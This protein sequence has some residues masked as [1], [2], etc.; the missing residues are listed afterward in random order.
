MLFIP[1]RSKR[2]SSCGSFSSPRCCGG[3]CP[4][5]IAPRM[6]ISPCALA[7]WGGWQAAKAVPPVVEERRPLSAPP[8]EV[9]PASEEEETVLRTEISP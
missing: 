1:C 8:V 5:S 3:S 4:G 9:E 7:P 2:L 6:P